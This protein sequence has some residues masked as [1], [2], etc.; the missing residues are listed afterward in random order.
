MIE[1]YWQGGPVYSRATPDVYN[2][3]NEGNYAVLTITRDPMN[4]ER[5]S[6]IIVCN[7]NGC[8]GTLPTIYP[9]DEQTGT[10][11]STKG[12]SGAFHQANS[13]ASDGTYSFNLNGDYSYIVNGNVIYDG[14][15]QRC[16]NRVSILDT[17][18]NELDT[19]QIS[20]DTLIEQVTPSLN[21]SWI[22]SLGKL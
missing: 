9:V 20:G 5:I 17:N 19:F 4:G 12:I 13:P 11:S 15:Y 8:D 22:Q 7:N 1:Y 21:Y 10:C 2:Q 3:V 18:L 14:V 6:S 16:G